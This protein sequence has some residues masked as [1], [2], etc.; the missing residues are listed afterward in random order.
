M[1]V[2]MSVN[3][4]YLAG[5][6]V[7][8][9]GHQQSLIW[10]PVSSGPGPSGVFLSDMPAMCLE[11]THTHTHTHL[12]ARTHTHTHTYAHTHTH[13]HTPTHT[14]IHTHTNKESRGWLRP[15]KSDAFLSSSSLGSDALKWNRRTSSRLPESRQDSRSFHQD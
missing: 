9:C 4:C 13:T 11:V 5:P 6:V 2:N 1:S 7:S 12:H 3:K 15:P 10:V 8:L 14:H